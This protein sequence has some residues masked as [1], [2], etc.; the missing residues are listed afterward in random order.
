MGMYLLRLGLS[1]MTVVVDGPASNQLSAMIILLILC[2]KCF[3]RGHSM[4]KPF[5][6]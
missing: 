3:F 1:G 2:P 4:K 6:P 5:E